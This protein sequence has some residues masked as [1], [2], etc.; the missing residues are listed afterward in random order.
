MPI[1]SVF[2]LSPKDPVEEDALTVDAFY[3]ISIPWLLNLLPIDTLTHL[4]RD[5]RET[6]V[7][8]P[9]V[10]FIKGTPFVF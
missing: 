3:R 1:L 5:D 7:T 4:Q 9:E 10:M 6:F 2:E 8:D